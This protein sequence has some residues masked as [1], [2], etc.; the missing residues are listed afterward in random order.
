MEKELQELDRRLFDKRRHDG[1]ACVLIHGQ[2]GGGKSHL[3]RQYVNKNRKKFTGG[4]FWIVSHLKEERDQAFESIYQKAVAREFPDNTTKINKKGQSFIESVKA[5]FESRHEWLIVFDGVTVGTDKDVTELAKFIPDSHNS[6]LIY[7][8][9]QKSLESKQRL[10]RPH[11]IRIPVLKADD[12]RKLLF[13]ELHIKK[14]TEEQIK[15]GTKLVKQVDCLPL[16][17][18]A[19][20]H[21]IADTHEPLVRYSMKSFSSN[22]KLEG[23]YNQILDDMQRLGHMEAWN[24]INVLAFYGQ[25]VP[26]E[27][28]H[29]GIK[30]SEN[31]GFKSTDGI[32][33]PDLNGTFGILM[34]HDPDTTSSRDS[35]VEPEPIDMLKILDSRDMLPEWLQHAAQLLQHSY[36]AADFKIKQKAQ[37]ARV[38]DYRYYLVHCRRLYEH[39]QHYEN[40][41]QSLAPIRADLEPLLETIKHQISLLEPGSS[42]ESVNKI[43]QASIFDR[44]TSSSDS[45]P[46]APSVNEVRTPS[47]RPSPLPLAHETLWGTDARKPSLESPA[48]IGSIRTP[49][50]VGHSPFSGYE[51]L[52]YESDRETPRYTSQPMRKN[53][54]EATERPPAHNKEDHEDGWQVVSSNKRVRPTRAGRDLG[55]FRPTPAR[56]IRA[57]VDRG[58]A[59][60]IVSRS[61]ERSQNRSSEA[62]MALSEVH[63]RSPPPTRPSLTNNVTS[64]WHRMPLASATNSHRTWASVAAGQDHRSP[65]QPIPPTQVPSI[66]STSASRD[67]ST[68]RQR[69]QF[70]SPLATEIHRPRTDNRSVGA[71]SPYLSQQ[72]SHQISPR[73]QPNVPYYSTSPPGSSHGQSRPRYISSGGVYLP[74]PVRGPNPS[75]LPYDNIDNN[76]SLSSKRRLPDDFRSENTQPMSYPTSTPHSQRSQ[77]P[78]NTPYP[79]Y[80]AYY[81]A[82]ALPAGYT[83]QPM[84][85]DNSHQS[86]IS[87]AETEPP[88]FAP[89]FTPQ[90]GAGFTVEPP[91]PRDRFPDGRPL[92]KSPRSEQ[93]F[94]TYSNRTSPHDLSKSLPGIGDWA[95]QSD[96]GRPMSRSSSGP[97]VA[98]EDDYGHGLGIVQ[99]DGYLRFGEHALISVEE[100]R[101]RT[102]EWEARLDRERM[103]WSGRERGR[104]V[105]Y[106]YEGAVRGYPDVNLIPTGSSPEAMRAMIGQ[107]ERR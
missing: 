18:D 17:I 29:L 80:G 69:N 4:I 28:L 41:R 7:I 106:P 75:Q 44:T 3:A 51:D 57:E 1:T 52:G 61:S 88:H 26:V 9:R 98:I 10:L 90:P 11:A 74:P 107:P 56:A 22:P 2:P 82:S 96:N 38:S 64:L 60:G 5:W 48:S 86:H 31:V 33:Q 79:P 101:Q 47:H 21:R 43:C 81:P 27:M 54:S 13:K 49:R 72:S 92:R 42:Q 32:G 46:S 45:V 68:N 77:S 20:S 15:H 8:S 25:H 103:A 76:I 95:H 34:R 83:S 100:A 89:P 66:V 16:A 39:A 55:S 53:L 93:A 35:L 97:G 63:S 85:R 102:S 30:G 78:R 70:S 105:P 84:S 6:S 37:P 94:P 91:S 19:I 71:N 40:K 58:L 23:T 62:K 24:L 104:V 12:A 67:S 50:I 36:T 14:P 73:T 87:A 99:F 59:T 65:V